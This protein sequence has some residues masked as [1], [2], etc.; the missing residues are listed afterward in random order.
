MNSKKIV[1]SVLAVMLAFGTF[2]FLPEVTD[3]AVETAITASANEYYKTVNG[4]VL[5]KDEDGD[6]FVSDYT[7]KGGNITIPKEAK[8]I[9]E[10]AF[11]NNTSITSVTLPA[12]TTRYGI[13]DGAF[14][15][16]TSLTS[17]TIGGDIGEGEYDGIGETAFKGCH[18][19]KK[20]S[21]TKKDA[22]V[23]YIDSYAFF[24]CYALKSVELPSNLQLICANS[25]VNCANLS[26][27]TIP[28]KTKIEGKYTFGYMFGTKTSDDYYAS[29]NDDTKKRVYVAAN[30]RNEVYWEI[31]SATLEEA[32]EIAKRVFGKDT[33]LTWWG[34]DD[35]T[36][37]EYSFSYPIRQCSITLKVTAGSPA[38]SWA[39]KQKIKYKSTVV[40][41]DLEAPANLDA[42]KTK[43]SVTLV[44]DDVKNAS[45]YK[46]YRYDTAKKKYSLFKT[47]SGTSCK[48][49]GLKSNTKYK[50]KV[51]A[52]A[53]S[54][55][56]T[57]E[58]E[59]A[60]ITVTTKK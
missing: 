47:V 9:G 14:E 4:F 6:V 41:D 18:S 50:F 60:T 17:V 10:K 33:D 30:G 11:A 38:E 39:K 24:S 53:K 42:T 20:V 51:V 3:G 36:V 29:S 57:I 34:Y 40:I 26:S 27:I 55:G 32:E 37:A 21:F 16:C 23:S 44:W 58:S 52:I 54:G 22:Y 59:Y 35:G 15:Y 1:S 25:F 12:G 49:T 2:T 56:K 8:Y 31:S 43:N 48:V 13:Q 7:G 19:L 5:N 46:V 28:A 45:G